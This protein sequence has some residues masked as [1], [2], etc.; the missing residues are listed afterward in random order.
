MPNFG[1]EYFLAAQES[2]S[3]SEPRYQSA[4]AKNSGSRAPRDGALI[5]SRGAGRDHR[6]DEW[7]TLDDRPVGGRSRHRG[8][9]DSRGGRRLPSISVPVGFVSELPVGLTFIGRA[10]SEAVLIRLAYAFEQL[11]RHRHA[12]RYR[13]TDPLLGSTDS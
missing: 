13:T 5:G 7:P 2:G 6:A 11:T 8:E 12:P 1:Q 9:L 3:L 4:L 10:W